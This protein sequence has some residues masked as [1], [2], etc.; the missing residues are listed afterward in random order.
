MDTLMKEKHILGDGFDEEQLEMEK[1]V[2]VIACV[3]P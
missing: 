1:S 3:L 2:F